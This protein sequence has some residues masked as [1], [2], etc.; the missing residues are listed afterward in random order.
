MIVILIYGAI[1]VICIYMTYLLYHLFDQERKDRRWCKKHGLK[2]C[3]AVV[4]YID[5]V[6][7]FGKD[8]SGQLYF[9]GKDGMPVKVNRNVTAETSR[10]SDID[11]PTEYVCKTAKKTT[12]TTK[13]NKRQKRKPVKK[14]EKSSKTRINSKKSNKRSNSTAKEKIKRKGMK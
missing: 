3:E 12:T 2:Y 14:S 4:P 1:L 6:F 13:T 5:A 8:D 9:K 10:D 7:W 11:K